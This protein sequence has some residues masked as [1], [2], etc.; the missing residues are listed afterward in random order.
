M[1]RSVK[2]K[3]LFLFCAGMLFSMCVHAQRASEKQLSAFYSTAMKKKMDAVPV[4]QTHPVQQK[5][6]SDKPLSAFLSIE[7]QSR[8]NARLPQPATPKTVLRASQ[9]PTSVFYSKAMMDRISTKPHAL[10]PAASST[11][12]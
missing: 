8:L 1:N 12:N 2:Y 11:K 10:V 4:Q 7:M 5:R 9:K 6:A 3:L